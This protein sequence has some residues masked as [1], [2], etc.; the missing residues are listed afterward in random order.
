MGAPASHWYLACPYQTPQKPRGIPAAHP[1]LIP[2]PH[3]WPA[4]ARRVTAYA[5]R[6]ELKPRP[7][8]WLPMSVGRSFGDFLK[9][10]PCL[11][12]VLFA[13][14]IRG[15]TNSSH[16][17]YAPVGCT[18]YAHIDPVSRLRSVPAATGRRSVRRSR[19]II[20]GKAYP[21]GITLPAATTLTRH[22]GPNCRCGAH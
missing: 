13:D 16:H 8:L 22:S 19:L 15:P 12:D 9:G 6:L 14:V 7:A 17:S 18:T 10:F 2:M 5:R 3:H 11:P 4:C 21:R 20:W 1:Y